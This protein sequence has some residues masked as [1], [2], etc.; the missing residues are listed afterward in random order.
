[1]ALTSRRCR[2]LLRLVPVEK[3]CKASDESVKAALPPLLKPHFEKG[4]E[5]VSYCVAFKSRLNNGYDKET[6]YRLVALACFYQFY[7]SRYL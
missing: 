4:D 1:M 3:V 7:A 2:Y 5:T 6:A